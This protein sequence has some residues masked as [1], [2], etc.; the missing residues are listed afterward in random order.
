MTDEQLKE[1]VEQ[2]AGLWLDEGIMFGHGGEGFVRVNIACQRAVVE[3]AFT[4][5]A[6][7]VRNR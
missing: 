6:A 2:K 4:Q 3:R 7:A 5:L 1:F